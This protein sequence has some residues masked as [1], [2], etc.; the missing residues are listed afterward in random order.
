MME[1][2]LGGNPGSSADDAKIIPHLDPKPGA[3]GKMKYV[4]RL[5]DAALADPNM[6]IVVEYSDD[7][8]KWNTAQHEGDG[9]EDITITVEDD[10]YAAGVDR[11]S[12]AFPTQT[13][14][15]EECLFVRLRAIDN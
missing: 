15:P 8:V 10:F 4:Y 11:V 2:V 1:W 3:N 5:S 7:M 12:I 9:M 14:S 13:A 6:T